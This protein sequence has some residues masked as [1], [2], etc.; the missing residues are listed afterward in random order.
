[1]TLRQSLTI[2]FLRKNLD[3]S[4]LQ[5]NQIFPFYSPTDLFKALLTHNL[6]KDDYRN[7]AFLDTLLAR[8]KNKSSSSIPV[9]TIDF[10]LADGLLSLIDSQPEGSWLKYS[11]EFTKAILADKFN[12]K[13]TDI[14]DG[15]L[16]RWYEKEGA[17]KQSPGTQHR[18]VYC[19]HKPDPANKCLVYMEPLG[20]KK[21]EPNLVD[22][23]ELANKLDSN[24]G[25]IYSRCELI[26]EI[27]YQLSITDQGPVKLKIGG[28]TTEEIDTTNLDAIKLREFIK[29]YVSCQVAV[30][31]KGCGLTDWNPG[32]VSKGFG[33]RFLD[34]DAPNISGFCET[35]DVNIEIVSGSCTIKRVLSPTFRDFLDANGN[36]FLNDDG[37]TCPALWSYRHEQYLKNKLLAWYLKFNTVWQNKPLMVGIDFEEG[38][39]FFEFKQLNLRNM[40]AGRSI[41]HDR[42]LKKYPPLATLDYKAL[43]Y[44]DDAAQQI[45]AVLN[46]TRAEYLQNSLYEVF[47]K[48]NITIGNYDHRIYSKTHPL[49]WLSDRSIPWHSV[50]AAVGNM[51]SRPLYG[52]AEPIETPEFPLTFGVST[53]S[54][55][56]KLCSNPIDRFKIK[57][58]S[59]TNNYLII[60]TFNSTDIATNKG[61]GNDYFAEGWL[62]KW[63]KINDQRGVLSSLGLTGSFQVSGISTDNTTISAYSEG[64]NFEQQ[65]GWP[66]NASTNVWAVLYDPWPVFLT[67]IMRMRQMFLASKYKKSIF[68]AARTWLLDFN[69]YYY[70]E[71]IQHALFSDVQLMFWN[72]DTT[73]TGGGPKVPNDDIRVNKAVEAFNENFP[74]KITPLSMNYIWPSRWDS[75]YV[76]SGFSR[77]KDKFVHL[78][79]NVAYN[80]TVSKANNGSF[81][82]LGEKERIFIPGVSIGNGNFKLNFDIMDVPSLFFS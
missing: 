67:Q 8:S 34:K 23:I 15:V 42:F 41:Y 18:Y 80:I 53:W 31:G 40:L 46:D 75:N 66:F 54:K 44:K 17:T 63:F 27:E 33:I 70:D 58:I 72:S 82:T 29:K 51:V 35:I 43:D 36:V 64:P 21:N 10:L 28:V 74:G 71:L 56:H 69:D 30:C 81:V 73:K 26:P 19:T 3:F 78:T 59:R 45:G 32:S 49:G 20:W 14:P 25:A 16:L 50:G 37:V 9:V 79:H 47:N 24:N 68:I 22:P 61:C 4:K 2:E 7:I 60:E 38:L 55:T 77:G 12:E 62:G 5:F 65:S 6:I 57:S 52:G 39:G 1:M 48:V 76:M 13:K 11:P